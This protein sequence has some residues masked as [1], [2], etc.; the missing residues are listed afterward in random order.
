RTIDIEEFVSIEDIDPI[1]FD[2]P[3]WAGPGGEGAAKPY[4]LLAKAM[5]KAGRIAV[6]R[7]VMHTKQH[8]AAIRPVDGALAVETMLFPDE[9]VAAKD[10]DGLPVKANVTDREMK[11]AAQLIDSLTA[12]W[13]PDQFHDT[14]REELL[15][16]IERKAKG[17]E[18]VQEPTEE[19]EGAKVL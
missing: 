10:I 12:D 18:I 11:A 15:D 2:T 1:Q 14:Y 3:Y 13:N 5:D 6:G 9:V 7:F 16:R 4:A 19:P 8:L 17:E